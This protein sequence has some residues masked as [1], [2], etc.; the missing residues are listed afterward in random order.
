MTNHIADTLDFN[1]ASE[2]LKG[3]AAETKLIYSPV[4]SKESGNEI[5]IKPE[6]LQVTG[7]FKVRGA[8]NKIS[9]LS[10]EEKSKGI[11]TSSAGNHAQGCALSA[12][13]LGIK[14]TIVMPVTTPLLKVNATRSYG[15]EVV[16]SGNVYDDAYKEAVRLQEEHGYTFV[17]AFDDLDV[18]E[19]QGTIALE[20]LN[21][22]KDVDYIVVPVGGGGLISGVSVAAKRVNPNVKII[23]VEPA[24]A[25]SMIKALEENE[26]T[27]LDKVVTIAD[28]CAVGKA[29]SKT[30]EIV[31][32]YVDEIITIT[33]EELMDAFLTLLENHKLI[34]E[35]SGLLS[36]AAT[37][38]LDVKSKKIACIISGGNID[39]LTINTLINHGLVSRGRRFCF[40]MNLPDKPG[41][42]T[43]VTEILAEQNAN[44]IELSHD[45]YKGVNK[46]ADVELEVTVIT[47]S[48]EHIEKIT[49]AF[50]DNGF[51]INKCY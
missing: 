51:E 17:H 33:D 16:L 10:E 35:N 26:V 3:V 7:S 50:N 28:G 1:K 47:E 12:Q 9:K 25:A 34:A 5:Y 40:T 32:D 44:V 43:K 48:H 24:G 37:K 13:K 39:V 41:Q 2:S 21:E 31:K 20:I 19:G 18:V 46:F 11:I 8:Y 38:K 29:G 6:N 4:F 42:L 45:R 49:K 14:A 22:L 23:G 27:A 36:L 15:A 30:Y